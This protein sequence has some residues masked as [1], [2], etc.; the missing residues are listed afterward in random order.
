[1]LSVGKRA[2]G[3][4]QLHLHFLLWDRGSSGEAAIVVL[5]K[6][7]SGLDQSEIWNDLKIEPQACRF[8][9]CRTS[10]ASIWALYLYHTQAVSKPFYFP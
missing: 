1:M 4:E 5:V 10:S 7:E 6:G 3:N 9:G 2:T 8:T